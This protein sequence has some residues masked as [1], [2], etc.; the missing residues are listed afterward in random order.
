MC[1]NII[2]IQ[3]REQFINIPFA[4]LNDRM[5]CKLQ[6]PKQ[7][8]RSLTVMFN[9]FTISSS[10]LCCFKTF[11]PFADNP[12]ASFKRTCLQRIIEYN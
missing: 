1:L 11:K 12:D 6:S 10:S 7:F 8:I 4:T 5:F 2:N 3:Y 9:P